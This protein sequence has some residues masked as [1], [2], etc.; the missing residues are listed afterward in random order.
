M[1]EEL[2]Q[3]AGAAGERPRVALISGASGGIGQA[4]AVA[5]AADGFRLALTGR[6]SADDEQ[7]AAL[8]ARLPASAAA[9]YHRCEVT[10]HAAIEQTV[11]DAVAVHG[12][13]AVLVN[14]VGE[15][16]DALLLRTRP[17]AWERSLAVNL[18]AAFHFCRCA[19]RHLL[20]AKRAGRVISISSVVAERGNAGQAAYAAAKAGLLGLTRSLARELASRGVT[21]NAVTPGYIDTAMTAGLLAD[22]AGRAALEAQI[23]LG[24]VGRPVEVA[25][26]VRFLASE[27]AAYITGEVLRVNGGLYM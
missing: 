3:A 11:K 26:A 12:G 8:L 5:L 16:R 21:V 17:E 19:T 23:P 20:A 27:A 14:N 6:R 2:G 4:V 24:R 1:S 9:S 18:S 25:A 22:D 10:E 7:V 13:L 15:A